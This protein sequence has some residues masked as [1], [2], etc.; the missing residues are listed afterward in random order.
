VEWFEGLTASQLAGVAR[1]VEWCELPAGRRVQAR[2]A[3]WRGVWVPVVGALEARA[4]DGIV[5][6][7]KRPFAAGEIELIIGAPATSDLVSPTSTLAI[8]VPAATYAGLLTIGGFAA[9]TARR[10]AVLA[11]ER[12]R[13]VARGQDPVPSPLG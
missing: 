8:W 11:A 5:D 9:A 12:P 7:V 4:G 6:V 3:L 13:V 10:L 2:G 1:R